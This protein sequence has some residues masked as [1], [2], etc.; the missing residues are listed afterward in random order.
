VRYL[1]HPLT[2]FLLVV[3]GA[4]LPLNETSV[5]LIVSYPLLRIIGKL[6]GRRCAR[7]VVREAPAP[8]RLFLAAPGFVG[9]AIALDVLQ[10]GA[11]PGAMLAAVVITGT[12]G[13]EW[14]SLMLPGEDRRS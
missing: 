9:I 2:V 4:R 12:L 14:L 13:A 6:A 11:Q 1:Q 3:A 7:Q 8:P 10:T 5:G